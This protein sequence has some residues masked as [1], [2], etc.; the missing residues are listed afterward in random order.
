VTSRLAKRTRLERGW[1]ALTELIDER[2]PL[3]GIVGASALLIVDGEIG[4]RHHYGLADRSTRRPVD[5]RTI[6]HYAS[7]TK[8][9]TAIGIMQ[10][11]QRG[12]LSLEDRILD[13]VPELR[14]IHDPYDALDRITLR[15]LLSHSAGFQDPTWPYT[16]GHPWQPFEPRSWAQ[17]VAM[18]PYQELHFEPGTRYGYSNP[19][20]IYLGRVIEESTGDPWGIYVQKNI[21]APLEMTRSYFGTTPYHLADHR[22]YSYTVR[23]GADPEIID[24]GPDF[25]TGVTTPNGGWN[26]P[27]DD[28]A[29]LIGFLLDTAEGAPGRRRLP[30]TILPR[31][32]IHE[33]WQPLYPT[34]SMTTVGPEA[35]GLSFYIIG[36][37]E[38]APDHG[39]LIG[40]AGFQAG[41]LAAFY[42]NPVRRTALAVAF[43]TNDA[44]G[45]EFRPAS[46]QAVIDRGLELL[47]TSD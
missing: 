36:D 46:Y 9:L 45:P 18:M 20:F 31:A 47:S 7:I 16:T 34:G 8:I 24:L 14:Q 35:M 22:S 32:A 26:G 19:A 12:Q 33:M 11:R 5:E 39:P 30:D 15:M 40:H 28:L 13:Y 38:G 6:F 41:F 44:S 1:L 42:L 29:R 4:A 17:L 10:L 43:N 37:P 25:D 23:C 2:A 27:L 21:F 3:D